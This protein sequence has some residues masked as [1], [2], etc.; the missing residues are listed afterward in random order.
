MTHNETLTARDRVFAF[1]DEV[2]S[3]VTGVTGVTEG[4]KGEGAEGRKSE[5]QTWVTFTLAGESYAFPVAAVQEILRVGTITR[6]PDAP[7][8]VRG[9]LNLRGR[10][11][12]VVDL[13]VRLGLQPGE[14]NG[15]SRVLIATARGRLIGLLVDSVE[16][17]VRLDAAAFEPPP[18]D[19][20][21]E[22]SNY[23][24]AV[25]QHGAGL[26]ILLDMDRVLEVTSGNTQGAE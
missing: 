15:S 12:P 24:R 26:L 5:W 25:C 4:R 9:I 17:V 10:V 19:V 2:N 20:L 8:P 23:L 21:T 13:R 14:A 16:Q 22:N 3:K 7:H 18:P 6:V 1:A 11:V